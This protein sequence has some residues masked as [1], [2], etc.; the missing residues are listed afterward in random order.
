MTARALVLATLAAAAPLGRAQACKCDS[1]PD[2]AAAFARADLV[3]LGHPVARYPRWMGGTDL[4]GW[5]YSFEVE[6]P[7]KGDAHERQLVA[8]T[9]SSC[10]I[11]F[12]RGASYVVFA[13]SGP[14]GLETSRCAY[15][16]GKRPQSWP[17]DVGDENFGWRSQA[18]ALDGDLPGEHGPVPGH[19]VWHMALPAVGLALALGPLLWRR[20]VDRG[21]R[22]GYGRTRWFERR[23]S[24]R[25]G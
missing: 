2:F 4:L 25:S 16:Q 6:E 1:P 5:D 21:R 9:Y 11:L 13:S 3:F 18:P 23:G 10:G 19:P 17:P 22:F 20:R 8:S 14:N 12:A 15:P 24:R 7:L